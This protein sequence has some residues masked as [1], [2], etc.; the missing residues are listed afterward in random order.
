MAPRYPAFGD[1]RRLVFARE[2]SA[3][4]LQRR[5][6][7][8]TRAGRRQFAS[9]LLQG[10]ALHDHF[11]RTCQ[12]RK[13]ESFSTEDGGL[14]GADKLNVVMHGFFESDHATGVHLQRFAGTEVKFNV[15]A[16]GMD[17]DDSRTCQFFEDEAFTA[18]EAGSEFLHECDVQVDGSLRGKKRIALYKPN[19]SW[20][21]IKGLDAAGV[22][23]GK[24]DFSG[25]WRFEVGE[26]QRFTHHCALEGSPDF[27]AERCAGHPGFP[28]DV[29]GFV[30]HLAGFGK[31]LLPGFELDARHLKVVALNGVFQRVRAGRCIDGDGRRNRV[32]AATTV[33]DRTAATGTKL[34]LIGHLISTRRAEGHKEMFSESPILQ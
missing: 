18:K 10:H 34:G 1:N 22:V 2:D 6:F 33:T 25:S 21:K 20:L 29:G 13:K 8:T 26:E 19:L 11:S 17:K 3:E 24:S 27:L 7:V 14:D 16:A 23:A 12:R 32:R 5:P 31:K 28:G 9:H 30:E 15:V 4:S